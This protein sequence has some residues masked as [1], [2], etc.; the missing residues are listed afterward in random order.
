MDKALRFVNPGRT[1]VIGS[2]WIFSHGSRPHDAQ[3]RVKR[4]M[5]SSLLTIISPATGQDYEVLRP[6]L[7]RPE[8]VTTAQLSKL[9]DTEPGPWAFR[10]ALAMLP[11]LP[12]LPPAKTIVCLKT[13]A[14]LTGWTEPLACS[15][16]GLAATTS[17]LLE[18]VQALKMESL[19]ALECQLIIPVLDMQSR[20]LPFN[21]ELWRQTLATLATE[22]TAQS[23][24]LT[25]Y[26]GGALGFSLFGQKKLD[27]N[28]PATIKNGLSQ[29][30]N[31]KVV[32]VGQQA[33]KEINHPAT[34]ILLKYRENTKLLN[35][36]GE[37]FLEHVQGSRLRGHFEPLGTSSG[38]LACHSPNLQALPGSVAFQQCLA[39]PPGRQILHFDYGAF[40]LRILASLA[41]DQNMLDIFHSEQDIHAQVAEAV[42]KQTVSK[43]VRPHLR[44]QAKILNFGIIYGMSS[45]TMAQQLNLST[46]KAKQMLAAY[47]LK[48]HKIKALLESL[49]HKALTKG[50]VNTAL[51][52]R[53]IFNPNEE[54][55]RVRRVARNMPIQGTGAEIVKLAMCRVHQ[56]LQNEFASSY[57]INSIHDELVV[58][59]NV[60]DA[61]KVGRV[62]MHEMAQAFSAVLPNVRPAIEIKTAPPN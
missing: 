5:D 30:F 49:E 8:I 40:E 4:Y 22:T 18:R 48:F 46:D 57:L 35:T 25:G 50:Y 2:L 29:L 31:R 16:E 12:V 9:F 45:N 61:T 36:Y 38:R 6:T 59:C 15:I 56:H 54:L 21:T 3:S 24:E 34:R 44:D 17:G 28:D 53:L 20:G 58:E 39:P 7:S 37:T 47:F 42:F 52:R 62:V 32:D 11:N 14:Q 13:L 51:G 60:D 33:L 26:L 23:E 43:T 41:E 19:A 1:Q 27:F 55:H 10:D